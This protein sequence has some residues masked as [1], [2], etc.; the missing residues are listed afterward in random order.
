M[1]IVKF[2]DT[3]TFQSPIWVRKVAWRITESSGCV[4]SIPYM[5]KEDK[6]E[7]DKIYAQFRFQ[8][9]IWVRKE[10]Q[11]NECYG[12]LRFNPLYG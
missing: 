8:S 10:L 1:E 7:L 2:T 4:V 9:P 12:F 5:G 11:M 6:T 3:E